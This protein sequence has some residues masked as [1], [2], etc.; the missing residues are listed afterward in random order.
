MLS[1]LLLVVILREAPD[2]EVAL[3]LRVLV[4]LLF[5]NELSIANHTQ[6]SGLSV[7]DRALYLL[8]MDF[9]DCIISGDRSVAWVSDLLKADECIGLLVA[10]L[11]LALS[12]EDALDVT[13][14]REEIPEVLFT[15]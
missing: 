2:E 8:S 12:D 11:V 1:Q 15:P 6:E 7:N 13:I 14:L 10:I 9:V 4:S 5:T 3:L